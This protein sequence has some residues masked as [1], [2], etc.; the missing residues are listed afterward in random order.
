[1]SVWKFESPIGLFDNSLSNG[2][3]RKCIVKG[4]P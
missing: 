2:I 1:M 3:S 4:D